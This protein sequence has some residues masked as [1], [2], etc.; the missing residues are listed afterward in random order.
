MSDHIKN[1]PPIDELKK[2]PLEDLKK[3]Y[4]KADC[5]K[6]TMESIKY[7]LTLKNEIENEKS[8]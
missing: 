4:L 5:F 8:I 7:I 3:Y 6:G 2:I 1:V